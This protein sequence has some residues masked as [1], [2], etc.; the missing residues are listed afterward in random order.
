MISFELPVDPRCNITSS[1]AMKLIAVLVLALCGSAVFV[2]LPPG[3]K[4]KSCGE[5]ERV[6]ATPT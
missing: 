5:R 4:E 6:K 1:R 3:R 2:F